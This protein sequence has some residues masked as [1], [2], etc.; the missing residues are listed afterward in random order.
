MLIR[1]VGGCALRFCSDLDIVVV[2][3]IFYIMLVV[4][5]FIGQGHALPRCQRQAR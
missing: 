1:L 5:T 3:V 2:I 4:S